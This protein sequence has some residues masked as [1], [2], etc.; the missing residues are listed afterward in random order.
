MS[1]YEVSSI[2]PDVFSSGELSEMPR[3]PASI[4]SE[5]AKSQ[6]INAAFLCDEKT[7]NE[8]VQQKVGKLMMMNF[9]VCAKNAVSVSLINESNGFKAQVF[10]IDTENYKTDFIQLSK[11]SNHLRVQIILK[12]GQKLEDSLV[13]LTGS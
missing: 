9:K 10:K 11:G 5:A 8:K 7:K 1:A 4:N 6:I 13:I 2:V 12:D 3:R